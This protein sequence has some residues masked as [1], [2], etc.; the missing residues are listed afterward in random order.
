[1]LP[2]K[3]QGID[4]TIITDGPA[5]FRKLKVI[6]TE[7]KLV[8]VQLHVTKGWLRGEK[9]KYSGATGYT[10]MLHKQ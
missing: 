5:G 6:K 10:N 9:L 1:L 7:S 8:N 2:R 3:E 4:G